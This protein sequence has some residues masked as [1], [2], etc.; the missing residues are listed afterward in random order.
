MTQHCQVCHLPMASNR[1]G[2]VSGVHDATLGEILNTSV[3]LGVQPSHRAVSRERT[4]ID[5]EAVVVDTVEI[6]DQAS[7]ASD[8]GINITHVVT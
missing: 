7:V 6:G 4:E 5:P 3:E 1:Y 8:P 2:V